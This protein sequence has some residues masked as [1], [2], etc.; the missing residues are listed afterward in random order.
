[1]ACSMATAGRRALQSQSTTAWAAQRLTGKLPQPLEQGK[2]V[3][4]GT[5]VQRHPIVSF[6]SI[7]MSS[8]HAHQGGYVAATAGSSLTRVAVRGAPRVPPCPLA[9]AVGRGAGCEV[10][11]EQEQGVEALEPLQRL[12]QQRDG[13][14]ASRVPEVCHQLLKARNPAQHLGHEPQL[15]GHVAE[16]LHTVQGRVQ[17]EGE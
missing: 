8:C 10:V 16:V 7:S 9:L 6:H 15:Q 4:P 12:R 17:Q 14:R 5:P 13:D 1:M 2:A 3:L 11:T